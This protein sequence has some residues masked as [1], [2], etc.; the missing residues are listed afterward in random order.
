MRSSNAATLAQ[1]SASNPGNSKTNGT[2]GG[3]S[4]QAYYNAR[5][6]SGGLGSCFSGG[7]GSGAIRSYSDAGNRTSGYFATDYGGPGG[8]GDYYGQFVNVSAG[9][10]GN[11]GGA[12]AGGGST[13]TA[14]NDGTGGLLVLVVGGNLTIGASGEIHAKG[15]LG[16]NEQGDTNNIT[17]GSSGA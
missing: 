4:G 10:A 16:G 2:G 1:V 11:P 9:G 15:S 17:G 12:N 14:G 6:N 7:S 8:R 5:S 13:S 3:G